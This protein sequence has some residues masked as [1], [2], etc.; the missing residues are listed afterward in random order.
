MDAKPAES[1]RANTRSPRFQVVLVAALLGLLAIAF[2][3][4][5]YT[6]SIPPVVSVMETE[7]RQTQ[8]NQALDHV[9]QGRYDKALA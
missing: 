6:A 4:G 8:L 1:T 2:L 5:R 7:P 3:L 9:A